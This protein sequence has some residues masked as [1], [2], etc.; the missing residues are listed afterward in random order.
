MWPLACVNRSVYTCK[1]IQVSL[2][3][4]AMLAQNYQC[5]ENALT[6]AKKSIKAESLA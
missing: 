5:I 1:C 4:I 2:S 3:M 6:E